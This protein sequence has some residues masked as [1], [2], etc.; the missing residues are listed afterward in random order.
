MEVSNALVVAGDHSALDQFCSCTNDLNR[1]GLVLHKALLS[2]S[3]KG[4]LLG[5]RWRRRGKTMKR[6][7]C[8]GLI[9]PLSL[10]S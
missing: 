5:A 6:P 3:P 10:L 7:A 8:L 9:G 1:G 2:P 4:P